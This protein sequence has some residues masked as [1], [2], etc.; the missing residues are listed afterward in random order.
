V[1]KHYKIEKTMVAESPNSKIIDEYIDWLQEK[2]KIA[3]ENAL[4]RLKKAL[5]PE[6]DKL[7][8]KQRLE[9]YRSIIKTLYFEKT[10][11]VEQIAELLKLQNKE[12]Q[13]IVDIFEDN[14]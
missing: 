1:S 13:E 3:E 8:E 10:W 6:I 14:E 9:D 5:E 11:N 2:R 12:V 7:F 4:L